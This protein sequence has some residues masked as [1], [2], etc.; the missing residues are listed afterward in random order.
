MY[1]IKSLIKLIP[2]ESSKIDN[3]GPRSF[4][5]SLQSSFIQLHSLEIHHLK[6]FDQ[7]TLQYI[8]FKFS[9]FLMFLKIFQ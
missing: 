7:P 8:Y 1:P 4:I 5:P 9:C 2:P 3:F 6:D